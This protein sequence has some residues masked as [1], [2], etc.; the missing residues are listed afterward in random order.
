MPILKF[1]KYTIHVTTF[2]S[3]HPVNSINKIKKQDYLSTKGNFFLPLIIFLKN[4]ISCSIK[5][6]LNCKNV[7]TR[8]ISPTG[9][10][11]LKKLNLVLGYLAQGNKFKLT[12]I[13]L[14]DIL[15]LWKS[16]RT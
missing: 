3:L 8:Q 6:H 13:D 2:R 1:S 5:I 15:L 10:I 16:T 14:N 12:F 4:E 9:I 7:R 11:S